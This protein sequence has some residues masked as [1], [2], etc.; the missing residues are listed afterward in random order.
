MGRCTVESLGPPMC[1]AWGRV[2]VGVGVGIGVSEAPLDRPME[3]SVGTKPA[4]EVR[5]TGALGHPHSGTCD[6]LIAGSGDEY[7]GS[8]VFACVAWHERIWKGESME[9]SK[10][11]LLVGSVAS[12]LERRITS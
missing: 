1:A 7:A 10:C 2:S 5:R 9:I 11:R 8:D 3:D 4:G 6:P 12:G